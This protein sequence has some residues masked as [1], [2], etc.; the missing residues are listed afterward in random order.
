M[1]ARTAVPKT[2]STRS[3]PLNGAGKD[4]DAEKCFQPALELVR[5]VTDPGHPEG[6]YALGA[7]ASFCK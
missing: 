1:E 7:S 2:V 3:H 6:A 4:D 5:A